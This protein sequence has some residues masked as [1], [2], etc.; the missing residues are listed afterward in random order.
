MTNKFFTSIL[1]LAVVCMFLV[2]QNSEAGTETSNGKRILDIQIKGNVSVSTTTVLNK[3]KI[4]SGDVFEEAALNKE[5][6]RLYAMGY[7]S[8]VFIEVEDSK[9]GVIVIF[10]VVEKPIIM[11][12]I[13]E[14]NENLRTSK[15]KKR[16]TVEEGELLD[17]NRLSQDTE[18]LETFY[19]E[20]GFYSVDV[21][22]RVVTD[23][24]GEQA[25]VT[26]VINEG[27]SLKVKRV[28]IEGNFSVPA[29]Q[30]K[31]L[32][33]TKSAWWF[34][35]KGAFDSEKFDADL[36]RVA[37]YYRSKGFLDA[38]V[39]ASRDYSA[40]GEDLY[41]IVKID[42]GKKYLVG[43]VE[44]KGDL[45]FPHDEIA[46]L[47]LTKPGDPF[48][49]QLIKED[50]EAIRM[51][52]Y[53][54][55]YM[56][57]E[58]DLQQMY[59][60]KTDGMSLTY[61]IKPDKEIS[62][63]K[64]F[65]AGNTKTKDKVIRREIRVYPGEKY[66]GKQLRRSKERIYNLGFFEDVY[67]E[68]VPTSDPE[69][70]DLNV[71]VKETK[72]G[73]F[74]F[75]GGYSSVDAFLGF[76]QIK[77]KNFDIS[78][79]P[80]FTGSGQDLTL[81]AELGSARTNYFL[82]WTDPWIF[83]YPLLFGFDL[84]REEHNRFGLSGYGYDE[85]RTGGSLRLG[86]ELTEY[87]ATDLVYN[88]EE[89]KISNLQDNAG[90]AL[91]DELGKNVISRLTWGTSY[92]RR[93]N[94]YAPSKGYFAGL[95]LQNAGG[96][97]G[98]DKDFLKGWLNG[99]YYYSLMEKVVLEVRGSLGLA[100]AYGDSEELPIY[101]R[102][103]A[104]GATTIR[105][106][107]QRAVGPRDPASSDAIGG[108]AMVLGGLEL[109]FPVFKNIIKGALFYDLGNVWATAGDMFDDDLKHGMGAGVRVKTPIG[110]LKLDYGY[111]LTDNYDDKK[112]GHFYFSVS[113]GF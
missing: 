76:V 52:Y 35:R 82:S 88:L 66:D 39:T 43:S 61:L 23:T 32:L 45:G 105:G 19:T 2:P 94:K 24:T 96:P 109:T 37:T 55:G 111:P 64:I 47:I 92:D 16:I 13:F 46:D 80:G 84:Y 85:S 15:L 60:P 54:R 57:A 73:E 69:V 34:I 33:S 71:T 22:F 9:D 103:Y 14:G 78:S 59:D 97:L 86:K 7:F 72:T 36:S 77:Q 113:Y 44:L 110:P 87:L 58:I 106:Y 5:L 41:L 102:F 95:S 26:F 62:V 67:F 12:I 74:S 70:K 38:K 28:E 107:E 63:G 8:D 27:T 10:T 29:D 31:K 81:R 50:L 4:Q 104:G 40:D 83:D 89:V 1:C 90:P 51:F 48:D 49:Y 21:E 75:G 99:S 91:R 25:K 18:E 17:H 20:E 108:E 3:L 6:K 56:N 30:I 65:V 11:E 101:E 112:E 53:D 100:D 93:D 98:G 42:E 68:T 79:F